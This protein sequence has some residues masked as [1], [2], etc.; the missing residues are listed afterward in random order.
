MNFKVLIEKDTAFLCED[1]ISYFPI[2]KCEKRCV[3]MIHY[4]KPTLIRDIPE[5]RQCAR[6]CR[7]VTNE[8]LDFFEKTMIFL[9]KK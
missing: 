1:A 6:R 8:D 9:V 4:K 2:C 5:N 7:T 3:L